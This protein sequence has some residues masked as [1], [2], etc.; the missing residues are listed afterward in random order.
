LHTKCVQLTVD[1]NLQLPPPYTVPF[2]NAYPNN[3]E[4]WKQNFLVSGKQLQVVN[5]TFSASNLV[6][7]KQS[8]FY[9]HLKHT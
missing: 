1:L 7:S 2:P 8:F 9:C 3:R 5:S 4:R 6:V